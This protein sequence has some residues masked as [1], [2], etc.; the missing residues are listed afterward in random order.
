MKSIQQV[1]TI[2][3]EQNETALASIRVRRSTLCHHFL[4]RRGPQVLSGYRSGSGDNAHHHRVQKGS[5][6]WELARDGKAKITGD[7]KVGS[8][9]TIY[10]TMVAIEVEVKQAKQPKADKDT[11]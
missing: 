2:F 7:L 5:D 1:N 11:K 6:R 3:Y 10:Y 4:E 9:V 8:K